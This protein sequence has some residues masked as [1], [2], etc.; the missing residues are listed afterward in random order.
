MRQAPHNLIGPIATHVSFS[1]ERED[2]NVQLVSFQQ[3][4]VQLLAPIMHGPPQ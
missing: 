2:Y 4:L 1:T 3:T